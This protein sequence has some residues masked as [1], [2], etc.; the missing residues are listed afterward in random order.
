MNPSMTV[1]IAADDFPEQPP[2]RMRRAPSV[3]RAGAVFVKVKARDPGAATDL[4]D[5]YAR[6]VHG[7]VWRV[8]GPDRDHEDIVQDVFSEILTGV[9]TVRT[10][11]TLTGWIAAVTLN[12]VRNRL[13]SRAVRRFFT[14]HVV[15]PDLSAA[16]HHDDHEA[17]QLVKRAFAIL[18]D[19]T[20]DDRIAFVLRF[21]EGYKVAEVAQIVGCSLA[22]IHRRL[23]RAE[24]FFRDRASRDDGLGERVAAMLARK[25]K[26][27]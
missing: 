13:R 9:H 10:A 26:S 11:E 23:G 15:E 27:T 3:D 4:Y 19:L 17:R 21:V 22:T 20:A 18:T 14:G 12:T 8:L 25:G 1:A 2:A 7:L 16:F 6:L 24:I 5:A